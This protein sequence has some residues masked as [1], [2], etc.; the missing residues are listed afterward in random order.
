[1]GGSFQSS[2][3]DFKD[4][5]RRYLLSFTISELK[6]ASIQVCV[7]F[8]LRKPQFHRAGPYIMPVCSLDGQWCYSI[9]IEVVARVS[10]EVIDLSSCA[11]ACASYRLHLWQRSHLYTCIPTVANKTILILLSFWGQFV[12][13]SQV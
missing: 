12:E 13:K 10:K 8:F 9:G 6:S 1:M 4:W 5:E 7:N 3:L 2:N 11:C